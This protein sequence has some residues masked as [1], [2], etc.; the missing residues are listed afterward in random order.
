MQQSSDNNASSSIITDDIDINSLTIN[1][2]TAIK[3]KYLAK[4]LKRT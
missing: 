3:N 2:N 4:I 1:V